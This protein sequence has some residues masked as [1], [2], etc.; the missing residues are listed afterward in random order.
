MRHGDGSPVSPKRDRRTVPVSH[1]PVSHPCL[2]LFGASILA[3]FAVV[4]LLYFAFYRNQ[5]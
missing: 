3:A 2:R 1:P 4:A 5:R